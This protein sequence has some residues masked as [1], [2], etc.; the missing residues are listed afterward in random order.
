[1]LTANSVGA[2]ERQPERR[3]DHEALRSALWLMLL[4][5]IN[6]P[7]HHSVFHSALTLF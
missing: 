5:A 6:H 4:K 2:K 1:V 3:R 7:H